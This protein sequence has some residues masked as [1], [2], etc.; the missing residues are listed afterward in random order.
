MSCI[1]CFNEAVVNYFTKIQIEDG[2]EKR[3]PQVAL[4][5]PSRQGLSL[6]LNNENTPIMPII[7]VT[8]NSLNLINESYMARRRTIRPLIYSLN[9]NNKTYDG[10]ELMHCTYGYQID[11]MALYQ[12]MFDSMTEQ[13][14]FNTVEK[15][16]IKTLININNHTIKTNALIQNV[17][18]NDS[19][20][21]NQMPDESNRVFHGS[22]SFLLYGFIA[23]DEYSTRSVLDI[24]NNIKFT[25]I[26]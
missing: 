10:I 23:N 7:V 5:I 11:Y 9:K 16:Y 26:D 2:L 13:I 14:I 24:Q 4:A 6:N 19:T 18:I 21:Y 22:I 20:T 17:T 15:N 12:D 25:N 8:R 3:S 1:R